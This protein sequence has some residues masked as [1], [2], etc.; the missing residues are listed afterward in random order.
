MGLTAMSFA[1]PRGGCGAFLPRSRPARLPEGPEG[2][3]HSNLT[4]HA[5]GTC[6]CVGG[7]ILQYNYV[8]DYNFLISR[9]I[10]CRESLQDQNVLLSSVF[11]REVAHYSNTSYDNRSLEGG[12]RNGCGLNGT[13][14][15]HWVMH[16][17]KNKEATLV[18]SVQQLCTPG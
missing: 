2:G 4:P 15:G 5:L 3:S 1:E 9:K 13:L 14:R 18:C 7:S 10:L 17:T 8:L 6:P 16:I 11:T 12:G